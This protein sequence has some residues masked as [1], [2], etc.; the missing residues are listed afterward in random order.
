MMSHCHRHGQRLKPFESA[1]VVVITIQC[2]LHLIEVIVKL[3]MP[4]GVTWY[5]KV[6]QEKNERRLG[7]RIGE[8]NREDLCR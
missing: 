3:K 6:M 7:K 8:H 5:P 4:K 1:I 2:M